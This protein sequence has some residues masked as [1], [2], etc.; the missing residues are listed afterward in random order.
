MPQ[1]SQQ[2]LDDFEKH[3]GPMDDHGAMEAA[4]CAYLDSVGW[5]N[6]KGVFRLTRKQWERKNDKA[7][8][9]VQYLLEEWDFDM[10][11]T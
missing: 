11:D 1:A 9:A 10:V 3:F 6:D 8:A 7:W 5:K 2:T 4:A